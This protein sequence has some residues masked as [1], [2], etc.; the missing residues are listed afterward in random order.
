MAPKARCIILEVDKT[1]I[2]STANVPSPLPACSESREVALKWYKL[3]F[4][5]RSLGFQAK[6]YFD[7][8]NDALLFHCYK[9]WDCACGE[10]DYVTDLMEK[11]EH[12]SIKRVLREAS[13]CAENSAPRNF[14]GVKKLTII[15]KRPKPLLRVECDFVR[16]SEE[17]AGGTERNQGGRRD[18]GG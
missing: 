12:N 18:C 11:E 2:R 16:L 10:Q 7:R 1:G 9:P 4:A 5:D 17:Y 3:S 14:P 15:E 6:I 8:T 13:L